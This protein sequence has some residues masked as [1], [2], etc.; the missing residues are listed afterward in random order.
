MLH[1]AERRRRNCLLQSADFQGLIADCID[2]F[3]QIFLSDDC[4]EP[5]EFQLIPDTTNANAFNFIRE[6]LPQGDYRV[7]VQ[8]KLDAWGTYQEGSFEAKAAIGWQSMI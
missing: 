1:D 5:E 3:G 2:E 8:G 7:T 4:L 6:D